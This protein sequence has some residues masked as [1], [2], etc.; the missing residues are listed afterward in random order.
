MAKEIGKYL[1]DST[2]E[3]K[4]S[5]SNVDDFVQQMKSLKAI[6]KKLPKVKD[7]ISLIGQII[8]ILESVKGYIE[9]LEKDSSKKWKSLQTYLLQNMMNL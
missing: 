3:L 1:E 6:D 2:K 4:I 9:N 7:K 5:T 8:G